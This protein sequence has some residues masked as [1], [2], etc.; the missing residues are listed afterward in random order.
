MDGVIEYKIP[1][2]GTGFKLMSITVWRLMAIVFQALSAP[3]VV[4]L[5]VSLLEFLVWSLVKDHSLDLSVHF[6]D[7]FQMN[8]K[9]PSF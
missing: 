9:D 7:G 1:L 6:M 4:I 2:S 8:K 3:L 5:G